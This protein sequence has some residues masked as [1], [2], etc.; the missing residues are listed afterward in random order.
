MTLGLVKDSS[1]LIQ[2]NYL[3]NH[4]FEKNTYYIKVRMDENSMLIN[5]FFHNKF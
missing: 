4:I 5:L 3:N 2:S 1:I